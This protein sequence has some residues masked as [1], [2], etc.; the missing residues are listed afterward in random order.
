MSITVHFFDRRDGSRHVRTLPYRW[1]PKSSPQWWRERYPCN[2]RWRDCYINA[3]PET[4]PGSGNEF[5]IV[6]ERVEHA[7]AV[8][9]R[10]DDVGPDGYV[11]D[12]DDQAKALVMVAE[13]LASYIPI[14]MIETAPELRQAIH[15][16]KLAR[17][18]LAATGLYTHVLTLLDEATSYADTIL[19]SLE[20]TDVPFP[21]AVAAALDTCLDR[22]M[23][24]SLK[25]ERHQRK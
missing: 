20:S 19:A 10:D 15:E 11:W 24:E 21:T 8:V 13:R 9:Y 1:D 18:Q 4:C 22:L 5:I 14:V 2:L 7:G 23:G 25:L 6:V 3:A 16:T 17:E 12:A